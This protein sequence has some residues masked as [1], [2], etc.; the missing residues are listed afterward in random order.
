MSYRDNENEPNIIKIGP[1]VRKLV[2]GG[3]HSIFGKKGGQILI[4]QKIDQNKSFLSHRDKEN[5]PN[6]IEI[7][8]L[9]RKLIFWG[10]HSIFS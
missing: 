1:L 2:F 4:L 5:E 9:I 6:I 3:T 7:G 10:M 8:P